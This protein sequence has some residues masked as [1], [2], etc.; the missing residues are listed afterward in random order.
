LLHLNFVIKHINNNYFLVPS[1]QYLVF[2][3]NLNGQVDLRCQEGDIR[4][5]G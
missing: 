2:F 4:N 3:I 1:H 5:C